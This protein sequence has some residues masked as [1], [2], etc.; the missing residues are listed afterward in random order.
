M[1]KKNVLIIEDESIIALELS[2]KLEAA[3]YNVIGIANSKERAISIVQSTAPDLIL[4]EIILHG[5]LEGI[6]TI[7]RIRELVD[8]PVIYVTSNKYLETEKKLIQTKPCAVIGK[9][10][11]DDVLFEEIK[12]ALARA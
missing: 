7:K 6:E 4:S 12:K 3:G 9:P 10:F 2:L 1:R 11:K 8:V 5:G